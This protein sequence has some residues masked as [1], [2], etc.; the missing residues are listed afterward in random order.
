MNSEM[1]TRMQAIG[2]IIVDKQPH[3]IAFQ[4]VTSDSFGTIDL[5]CPR[6]IWTTTCHKWIGWY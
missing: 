1:S 3:V 6:S 4:E 5:S 2:Q